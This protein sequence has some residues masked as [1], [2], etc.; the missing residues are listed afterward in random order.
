MNAAAEHK[1]RAALISDRINR[2]RAHARARVLAAANY[3]DYGLNGINAR[4][5]ILL[6]VK[7]PIRPYARKTRTAREALPALVIPHLCARL[8]DVI[9]S[10]N[11][12]QYPS[13]LTQTLL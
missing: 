8:R 1:Y 4:V 6:A 7:R 2:T 11:G 12:H 13:R 9:G 10:R 3:D 5:M